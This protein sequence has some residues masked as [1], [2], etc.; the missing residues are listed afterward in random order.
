[1]ENL[2]DYARLRKIAEGMRLV[3]IDKTRD[4][5]AVKLNENSKVAPEKLLQFLSENEMASF[6]P[7]GILRVV[8]KDAANETVLEKARQT[9]LKIG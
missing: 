8:F 4:G 3:S 5:F 9:L 6:S 1:M 2:F 7:N